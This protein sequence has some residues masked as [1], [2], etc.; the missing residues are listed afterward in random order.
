MKINE[1]ILDWC[2]KQVNKMYM[3]HGL[4]DSVLEFQLR[5]N[6]IRANHNLPDKDNVLTDEGY[7]Q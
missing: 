1:T 5:I 4:T 7:V 2:Q 3:K 6:R